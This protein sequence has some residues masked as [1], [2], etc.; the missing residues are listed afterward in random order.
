MRQLLHS[1]CGCKAE[2]EPGLEQT[3]VGA[4]RV[5]WT[6]DVTLAVDQGVLCGVPRNSNFLFEISSNLHYFCI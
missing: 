6:V 1:W 2:L 3:L 5:F 4:R